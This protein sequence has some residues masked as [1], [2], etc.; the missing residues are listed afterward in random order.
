MTAPDRL[1]RDL[2]QWFADSALPRTPDYV[3]DVIGATSRERQ[4]PAWAVRLTSWL[5]SSGTV[6]FAD[7]RGPRPLRMVV[8]LGL[9][10]AML[11]ALA[12]SVGSPKRTLPPPTGPAGNGLIAYGH[13]GDILTLDLATRETTSLVD[14]PERD[15]EPRYSLDGSRIAFLRKVEGGERVVIVSDG[16]GD[17]VVSTGEP[18]VELDIDTLAWSPDGAWIAVGAMTRTGQA[19]FL[20]DPDDGEVV[21]LTDYLAMDVHWRP[22]LPD[23]QQELMYVSGPYLGPH[24]ELRAI[25]DDEIMT[26]EPAAGTRHTLRPIGWTPDGRSF[27]YQIDHPEVGTPMTHVRDIESGDEVV[28]PVA[29][30]RISNDGKRIVGYDGKEDDQQLC[31]LTIAIGRCVP[32]LGPTLGPDPQHSG[33]LRWS[34]D[35]KAILIIALEG[36]SR[37]LASDG[38]SATHLAV[39]QD[40]G[41]SWQRVHVEPDP[42]SSAQSPGKAHPSATPEQ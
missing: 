15:R 25:D 26:I 21:Q 7:L 4:R 17:E 8:L 23:G 28:L 19:I 38:T 35:D 40:G 32:I 34:P 36:W 37:V 29:Y 16:G 27:A 20:V 24:L 31:V 13:Q 42:S 30:G 5:P 3:D 41:Q 6:R 9:L 33:A 10:A 11:A 14:G 22:G 39:E 1:D 12:L 2:A 18:F